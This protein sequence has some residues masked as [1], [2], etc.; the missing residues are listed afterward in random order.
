MSNCLDSAILTVLKLSDHFFSSTLEIREYYLEEL[1]RN[2]TSF[3]SPYV[4][5]PLSYLG[6]DVDYL[7]WLLCVFAPVIL[8]VIFP[9]ILI[10]MFYFSCVVINV[11]KFRHHFREV[12]FSFET[13]AFHH[14]LLEC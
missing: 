6:L 7:V 2:V 9:M 3:L 14:E 1:Y 11:F 5:Q 13:S 8:G 12:S 10:S 4:Q